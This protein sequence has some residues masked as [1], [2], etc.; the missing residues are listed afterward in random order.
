MPGLCAL[1]QSAPANAAA[2]EVQLDSARAPQLLDFAD[3]HSKQRLL[4]EGGSAGALQ[5]ADSGEVVQ[6]H[7]HCRLRCHLAQR[8]PG[9]HAPAERA[10][11]DLLR[12]ARHR[13]GQDHGHLIRQRGL[14][15]AT[16][17]LS[18]Q[19]SHPPGRLPQHGPCRLGGVCGCLPA[20]WPAHG[21]PVKARPEP[22]EELREDRSPEAATGSGPGEEEVHVPAA[23]HT[24]PPR[25]ADTSFFIAAL[26]HG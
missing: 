1:P 19:G 17:A 15:T 11:E 21:I 10:P 18:H 7:R 14:G 24:G 12:H 20:V 9:R 26:Q 4:P 5:H 2:H 13:H 22:H 16:G 6:Q 3:D 8:V 25:A 23:N